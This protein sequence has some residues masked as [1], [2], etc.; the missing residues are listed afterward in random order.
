V[1][2][3]LDAFGK[4]LVIVETVGVGQNEF[5]VMRLAQTVVVVLV[6]EAG[7][8]VQ[9]MKAGLLEIADVFVVNKADREGADRIKAELLNMLHLRPPSGWDVPVLLTVATE[10]RG[11]P[12]LVTTIDAHRRYLENSGE[13]ATR[14][15]AGRKAEFLSLLRDEIGRLIERGLGDA[16]DGGVLGRI[17]RGEADPYATAR[18]ILS[19]P[20]RLGTIVRDGRG[21]S[22]RKRDE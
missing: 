18:E 11:V 19:D 10:G 1:T 22:Q 6:P 8:T 17:E 20:G 5:D 12:E 3:L 7:D 9:T 15:A 16:A 13:G 4:D 21:G 2:R 14:A